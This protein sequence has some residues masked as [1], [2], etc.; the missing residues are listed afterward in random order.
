M[1]GATAVKPSTKL[2][3]LARARQL[4]AS[5]YGRKFGWYIE[6]HGVVVG[7][8]EYLSSEQFWATYRVR[9]SSAATAAITHDDSRWFRVKYCYRNRV[10]DGYADSTAYCGGPP[11]VQEGMVMMRGLYL[12]PNSWLESFFVTMLDLFGK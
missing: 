8:L 5:N 1:A 7:E 10:L 12:S 4:V 6:L 11:F 3:A 2:S 9:A